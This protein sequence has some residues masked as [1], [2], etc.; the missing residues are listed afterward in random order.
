MV[1]RLILALSI[2][3]LVAPHSA[4]GQRAEDPER[5]A[6]L[7]FITDFGEL[8]QARDMNAIESLLRPAG[9]H[10]LTDDATT[11]GWAEYRDDH[12]RPW[13]DS[14]EDLSYAH[15]AVEP[16]VRGDVAWVAFRRAHSGMGIA[17]AEGRG[18]AVLEKIDGR[19]VIVHL[20]V[21]G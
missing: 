12:L 20:H 3:T 8:V 15:T 18:T 17:P 6:V 14:I 2:V 19:W 5:E 1:E 10:I 7:S 9:L 16:V 11:H 13:L 4:L 21:S